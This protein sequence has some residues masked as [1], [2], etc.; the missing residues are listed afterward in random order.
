V[1]A[2]ERELARVRGVLESLDEVRRQLCAVDNDLDELGAHPDDV[3]T[4]RAA[5]DAVGYVTLD[6]IDALI[7]RE[8]AR[9]DAAEKAVAAEQARESEEKAA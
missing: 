8:T 4:V 6:A 7:L 9:R 1:T 2:A 3:A 5:R